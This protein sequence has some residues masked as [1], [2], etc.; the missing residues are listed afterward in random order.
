MDHMDELTTFLHPEIDDAIIYITL[1]ERWP[2]G[3]NAPK[4]IVRLSKAL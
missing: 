2:E 4:I 1:P 3:L